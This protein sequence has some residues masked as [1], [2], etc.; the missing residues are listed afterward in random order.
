[1]AKEVNRR[2]HAYTFGREKER[3]ENGRHARWRGREKEEREESFDKCVDVV[4][5]K[6]R[7][8]LPQHSPRRGVGLVAPDEITGAPDEKSAIG[9]AS[10]R[11]F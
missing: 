2:L 11:R 5:C 6:F 4:A 7:P 1:M 10:G 9:C 3:E 8:A